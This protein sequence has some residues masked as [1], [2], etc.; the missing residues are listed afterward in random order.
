M[1]KY[2]V[3]LSDIALQSTIIKAENEQEAKKQAEHMIAE[4]TVDIE[5]DMEQSLWEVSSI[6]QIVDDGGV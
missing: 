6:E 4:G 5:D 2:R 3:W 1:N